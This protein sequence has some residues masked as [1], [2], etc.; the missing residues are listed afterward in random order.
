MHEHSSSEG[1]NRTLNYLKPLD[2]TMHFNFPIT[3]NPYTP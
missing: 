1:Y 2:F 3:Y